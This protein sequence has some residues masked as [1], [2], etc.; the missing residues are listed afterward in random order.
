MVI[1]RKFILKQ[2]TMECQKFQKAQRQRRV[3]FKIKKGKIFGWFLNMRLCVSVV[4]AVYSRAKSKSAT[5]RSRA[6]LRLAET[7]LTVNGTKVVLKSTL[8]APPP[9][10][11]LIRVLDLPL[12]T[13]NAAITAAL[14]AL[15]GEDKV[16]FAKQDLLCPRVPSLEHVLALT[17]TARI[18]TDTPVVRTL[19]L[20]GYKVRI[21]DDR[22]TAAKAVPATVLATNKK[23]SRNQQ[24]K[25]TEQVPQ[26]PQQAP[27]P[28]QQAHLD[29]AW[30]A[31]LPQP[32]QGAPTQ[33]QAT[34]HVADASSQQQTLPTATDEDVILLA[35]PGKPA[36][37]L[38]PS[39]DQPAVSATPREQAEDHLK[40][41]KAEEKA[42]I[43]QSRQQRREGNF[44]KGR[45][46]DALDALAGD[47]SQDT[48]C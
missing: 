39:S 11:V 24:P 6:H 46:L 22:K 26:P 32:I 41:R 42:R 27:Q 48:S 30:Q 33:Q 3:I 21:A 44:S 4:D 47:P 18:S 45:D 13:T 15:Y 25:E 8:V 31:P 7:G 20:E 36:R 12:G 17:A 19:P 28:P 2:Q 29:A 34:Q 37:P 35:S 1:P 14:K 10:T 16:L 9:P 43:T 38:L 5:S 40:G 23:R